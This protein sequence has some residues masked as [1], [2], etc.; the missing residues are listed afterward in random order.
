MD[1]A[2]LNPLLKPWTTP[3]EAPPFEDIK[4]E[5]F[6]PA[7]E[8]AMRLHDQ[9]IDAIAANPAA[10]TFANTIEAM[11]RS[12]RTLVDV[13]SV[14][15]NLTG[16]NTNDALQA[17]EREWS[18]K[19]A[20]HYTNI[21]TNAALFKRVDTLYAARDSLGLD[22]EQQ[23]LLEKS[24]KGFVR[25]GAKLEGADRD[26][27]KELSQSRAKLT[28]SFGQNVLADEKAYTLV[29]DG[30]ADLAGLPTFLRETAAGAAEERGL[31]GKYVITLSRSLIEPFLTFSTRRDLREQAW[32]AWVMRGENGGASDNRQAITDLTRLRIEVANLLGY[33]S[34]AAFTLEETMAKTPARVRELLDRV[35]TP[36]VKRAHEEIA[37]LQAMA[38]KEGANLE[39]EPWDWRYYSEK[40][41]AAEFDLDET[42]IKPY[43]PLDRMIEAAFYTATQLFGVTFKERTDIPVYHPDVRTFEVT[44]KDGRH[45][46]LFLGD[47][48]ARA[49]KRSGAWMSAYRR[50]HKLDG[51]TRP[52]IVNVMNFAKPGAGE[53][54]LLSF[55]DA[56]T[57][58]HE[59]GHGLHGLLSD[60]TYPSLACTAVVRDFV[61]LPSQLLEHWL[62]TPEIMTRF[63]RHAKTGEPM[64][65]KLMAKLKAARTF[66]QGFETVAFLGSAIVD[67]DFHTLES[68]DNLDPLA[69]EAATLARIG[70]PRQVGVRHRSTHFQHIFSGGYSAGY[71][72]Y[73]WSEVLD[74]D[75]F[76]AFEETG[77]V[78]DPATAEKLKRFVYSAGGLRQE[79]EAYTLFRGRLPTVDGLLKKR[80]L[81]A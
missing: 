54:T 15:W 21:S 50:Q 44:D 57:L 64:P 5:H 74:A 48:Y 17:L 63:A 18:P 26:R 55:D 46:G 39:I 4:P 43:L 14:F 65:A 71:Y 58:F 66:N 51:G 24:Y 27:Y 20:A 3:F 47:Y 62:A 2:E 40:V 69:L 6:S 29:L 16:S 37:K 8:A 1:A 59:F 23:R 80:G 73:L 30:E 76:S 33:K 75:A 45:V 70:M 25:S 79:D 10:P 81:A 9:E 41:R 56:R 42:E 52:I 60:V 19:Y 7:I 49:S 53:P 36:G 78:F 68:A 77:N 35:W 32:K 61:E 72:S 13:G 22:A 11:E 38:A 34:H 12:G 67:M 28:T 31:K